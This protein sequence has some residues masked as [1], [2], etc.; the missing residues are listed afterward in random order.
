[1]R[2]LSVTRH[3]GKGPVAPP[4]F[5]AALLVIL[6]VGLPLAAI[7]VAGA[8]RPD[9]AASAPSGIPAVSPTAAP[10]PVP[11]VPAQS[12]RAQPSPAIRAL[13]SDNPISDPAWFVQA[14]EAGFRLYILS[15]TEF[16]T[17]TPLARTQAQLAMAIDAGL[18]IAAYTRD[19]RCWRE[20]IAATGS[21][22]IR[23]QFFAL[24]IETGGPPLTRAMITGV[25][26]TGVRP[27]VYT[28]ARMWDDIMG[29]G[30]TEFSD[31]ALWDAVP[32]QPGSTAVAGLPDDPVDLLS[33]APIPF[34][35]WNASGN[36]RVGVQQ[37]FERVFNG[38][39]I[40]VNTFARSFLY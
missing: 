2:R 26:S 30:T 25:Q 38:V 40:D 31:V 16:G 27:V 34:G 37:H 8:I 29:A 13:D 19:Q 5:G 9:P 32:V 12:S 7:Q 22:R 36:L 14:Y 11:T 1:M 15:S 23:L 6:A 10:T 35:G 39:N 18:A 3:P 24:D 4:I 28:G 33:P 21:F 20:G 17:C